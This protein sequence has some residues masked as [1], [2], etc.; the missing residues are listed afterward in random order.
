MQGKSIPSCYGA[1][2]ITFPNREF[3][4]DREVFVLLMDYI[5]GSCLRPTTIK[6]MK[7]SDAEKREISESVLQ[8]LKDIKDRGFLWPTVTN[9]NFI[10]S[11]LTK[12]VFA[13]DFST[14]IDTVC[15]KGRTPGKVFNGQIQRVK[16]WLNEVGVYVDCGTYDPLLRLSATKFHS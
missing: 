9:T 2:V 7:L 5:K 14:V 10:R 13:V 15:G 6:N 8:I 11:D 12:K 4:E 16:K 1:F 3:E